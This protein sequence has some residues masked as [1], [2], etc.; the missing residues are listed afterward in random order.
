MKSPLPSSAYQNNAQVYRLLANPTRLAILNL[1]K[2]REFP[3]E[4]IVRAV[5]RSK[6]NISQ[7]LAVLRHA[8][9]VRTRRKGL[10]VFYKI[11][12]PRIVGPCHILHQ[13]RQ[14][15]VI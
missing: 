10:N 2:H 14:Q 11:V 4:D 7:H 13:L 3:V 6:A 12:D 5:R 1:I 8:R 15:K 9:L